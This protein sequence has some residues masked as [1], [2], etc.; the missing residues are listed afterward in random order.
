MCTYTIFLT[1]KVFFFLNKTHLK[2]KTIILDLVPTTPPNNIHLQIAI[3]N[4]LSVTRLADV[5][6]KKLNFAV[7]TK[8]K[9]V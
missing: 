1:I 5:T 8:I 2:D 9:F 3:I 7:D 6:L 4:T